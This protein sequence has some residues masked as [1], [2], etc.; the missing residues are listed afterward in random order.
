MMSAMGILSSF[1]RRAARLKISHC[2]GSIGSYLKWNRRRAV[3]IGIGP[4][5]IRDRR[6]PAWTAR[7]L[8]IR[9][10]AEPPVQLSVFAQF[11][12]V[13]LDSEA[14]PLRNGDRTIFVPHEPAR[15]DVVLK[16]VIVGIRRERQVRNCG[17]EVKHRR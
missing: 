12:I 4:T 13:Q 11:L 3:V 14:G 1:S 17:A 10:R 2:S 9:V 7:V 15:N 16:M 6:S 8:I 5:R